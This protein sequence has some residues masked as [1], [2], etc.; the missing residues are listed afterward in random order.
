[1]KNSRLSLIFNTFS[2]K[3]I[4]D[5]RKWLIS[6]AHNQRQDVRD[7]FEYLA[8]NIENDN[9][10]ALAKERIFKKLFPKEEY[11]DPR[12]RQ[13]IHFLAKAVEDFLIY[14]EMTADEVRATTSLASVFRKRGLEKLFNKTIKNAKDLH[15]KSPFRNAGFQQHEFNI[16]LEEYAAKENKKRTAEM[17]LQELTNALDVTFIANKLKYSYLMQAH[18]TVY[19]T[20][21]DFG[22][23]ESI[24]LYVRE[25]PLMKIPAIS[26]YYHGLMAQLKK[27]EEQHFENL[28]NEIFKNIQ[29]FPQSEA[30]DIYLMAIN[31][32][33]GK[34]NSGSATAYRELFELYKHGLQTNVFIESGIIS[35]F[36]FMNIVNLG[37][38]L[39]EYEWIESFIEKHKSNLSTAHRENI[40][41]F[42]FANLA[43]TKK[44]YS[45]AMQLLNQ[46]EFNDTL[47]NLNAKNMLVKMLYEE[48]EFDTLESLL[49][50]MRT[51]LT[52]KKV[53]GY[54]KGFIT[55]FIKLTQKLLKVQPY[56]KPQIAKLRTEIEQAKPMASTER[57]WLLTQ[58]G[59]V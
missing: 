31:Y 32:L 20:D 17:N 30:R 52:R 43:Y 22:T 10:K 54:H 8:K 37:L 6:P 57:D 56:N 29:L 39:N 23:L 35:R 53:M 26:I 2:K 44:D 42:C 24:L 33:I 5:L 18:K 34:I 50:S 12:F 4:R 15:E 46:A 49:S 14:Q 21:Y 27:E 45:K 41:H 16:Q 47:M 19:K 38:K 40:V 11:D 1:M 9:E 25:T 55:N 28:K 59:R 58:L 36:T 48:N 51:Y 13:T 3:E 7:L